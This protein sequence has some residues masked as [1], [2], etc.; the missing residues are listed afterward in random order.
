MEA[1]VAALAVF[2]DVVV[3]SCAHGS[4]VPCRASHVRQLC[5]TAEGDADAGPIRVTL[6]RNEHGRASLH[7]ADEAAISWLLEGG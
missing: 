7:P 5:K 4:M 1:R 6:W 2:A 3:I